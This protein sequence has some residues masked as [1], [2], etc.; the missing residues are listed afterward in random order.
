MAADAAVEEAFHV[1]IQA[2]RPRGSYA[3]WPLGN[4]TAPQRRSLLKAATRVVYNDLPESCMNI[5]LAKA[6]ESKQKVKDK[7]DWA[8]QE[9][10]HF[11]L[12][13]EERLT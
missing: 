2:L 7:K 9:V 5:L 8:F 11:L 13:L 4:M 10:T 3:A 12:Q 6:P 1:W